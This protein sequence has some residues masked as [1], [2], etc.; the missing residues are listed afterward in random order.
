MSDSFSSINPQSAAPKPAKPQV[1]YDQNFKVTSEY[2][3]SLPDMQN[4]DSANIHGANVPIMQVGI[5]NFRLPLSF[6]TGDQRQIT[7]ETSV[8]GTVSLA[9]DAKGI[10]MSR[11]MRVFYDFKDRVFD[12]ELLEEI[13]LRYKQEIGSSRARLKLNFNYPILKPSL[14]SNLEGWQYYQVA[15]E[16]FLDDLNRFRK[17]IHFDFVYSSACPCSSELSEHAREARNIYG[18]PH[19]QRSKARVS[20][21][22]RQGELISL[23]EVQ[24]LCLAALKTETQVMVKRED[25]Q[26]FAEMNGAF[27]KFVEDAA[28]LLYEQFDADRRIRDFQ[29]A[30]AHLESLHSHDAVAVINKG[31]EGGFDADFS[32]F[33]DLVC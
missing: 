15:F 33:K 27:V 10:N 12:L 13:L 29:I 17:V 28:R 1:H 5:N 25:E 30:C 26:A 22:V 24:Q 11:I 18:I 9:A 2:R 32:H 16:G 4:A 8:T 7:L 6:L 20:L 3:E 19:S 23:E 31:R 21:E 14:R